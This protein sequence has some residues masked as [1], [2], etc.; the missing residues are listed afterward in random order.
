[1]RVSIFHP[2]W[3]L[4]HFCRFP[5]RWWRQAAVTRRQ[6]THLRATSGA[7]R[8]TQHNI[9]I[10]LS[11]NLGTVCSVFSFYSY[12]SGVQEELQCLVSLLLLPTRRR[13][14]LDLVLLSFTSD[15]QFRYLTRRPLRHFDHLI[16]NILQKS[17]PPDTGVWSLLVGGLNSISHTQG[18]DQYPFPYRGQ[19]TFFH[20]NRVAICL[21]GN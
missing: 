5:F 16:E 10:S 11:S 1:M 7:I 3:T 8:C 14:C 20:D 9:A 18:L 6:D 19:H 17:S 12:S 13:S 21:S 2:V 15:I 4:L